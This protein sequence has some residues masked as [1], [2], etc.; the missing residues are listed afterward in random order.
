VVDGAVKLV[1]GD[2][3]GALGSVGK[4]L[5]KGVGHVLHGG[6]SAAKNVL[7]DPIVGGIAGFAIGGM[8]G[9]PFLGSMAGPF[10]GQAAAGA[11]GWLD[12][13]VQKLFGVGPLGEAGQAQN[14]ASF[15]PCNGSF[16]NGCGGIQ[17]PPMPPYHGGGCGYGGGYAPPYGGGYGGPQCGPYPGQGYG[18]DPMMQQMMMMGMM[19]QMMSTMMMMQVM[20]MGQG[21]G[22]YMG[23]GGGNFMMQPQFPPFG[24]PPFCGCAPGGVGFF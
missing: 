8:F 14:C 23:C 20:M 15:G 4:G 7:G 11:I 5:F 16:G 18:Q 22:G 19:S 17:P 1:S 9:M 12:G 21:G 3:L 6:L 13:G 24:R 2:P 10:V